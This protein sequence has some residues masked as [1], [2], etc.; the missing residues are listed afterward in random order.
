MKKIAK[1]SPS[2]SFFVLVIFILSTTA[3]KP[4]DVSS[5]LRF[6]ETY[7]LKFKEPSGL[8]LDL[9]KNELW[10]VSDRNQAVYQTDLKGKVHKKHEWKVDDPEGIALSIDGSII[11]LADEEKSKIAGYDAKGHKTA[12]ISISI[13]KDKKNGLE[14][15]D[16]GSNSG[17]IFA[18]KESNPG[19]FIH[20]NSLGDSIDIH[21]MSFFSDYSGI[22]I[23]KQ[24]TFAYL[25]SDEER[26]LAKYDF[27]KKEVKWKSK[28]DI[29]KMEGIAIDEKKK[30]LY[31]VSD[32]ENQLYIYNI[33]L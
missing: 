3:C 2:I 29:D 16:I 5:R 12:K 21:E 13:K 9:S 18:V 4:Q 19:L 11:Y 15:L 26:A 20:L 1:H 27:K 24:E 23:N 22:W 10:I 6:L 31:I 30:L 17:D 7:D 28:L 8:D 14:G 32:S 33:K 25:I